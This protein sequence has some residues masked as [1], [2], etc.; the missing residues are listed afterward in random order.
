MQKSC[1]EACW[2]AFQEASGGFKRFK[3]LKMGLSDLNL[4][5]FFSVKIQ[6]AQNGFER[7]E[8]VR[9]FFCQDSN[10]SNP[11]QSLFV[12]RFKSLKVKNISF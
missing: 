12:S 2:E 9:V 3:S 8:S 4:L 6:I 5:E 10:R 7:F 11:F 1:W